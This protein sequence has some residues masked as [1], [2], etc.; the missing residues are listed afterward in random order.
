VKSLSQL[1]VAAALA[2]AAIFSSAKAQTLD[3]SYT[4]NDGQVLSGVFTGTDAGNYFTVTG[5]QSLSFDTVP[6]TYLASAPILSMDYAVGFG[7][8][9]NGNGSAVVSLDGSYLDILVSSDRGR[10]GFDFFNGDAL[11][12]QEGVSRANFGIPAVGTD[13]SEFAPAEWSATLVGA[14]VPEPG[15]AAVLL[16]GMV[17]LAMARGRK[18]V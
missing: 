11:S 9:Y 16:T 3:W 6:T 13:D 12:Q 5:L 2:A 4:F 10:T 17:G 18:L 14:A 8:G 7:E 1:A 15:T